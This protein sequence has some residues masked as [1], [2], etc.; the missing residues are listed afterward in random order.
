MKKRCSLFWLSSFIYT[1]LELP[2]WWHIACVHSNFFYLHK[3]L[4]YLPPPSLLFACLTGLIGHIRLRNIPRLIKKLWISIDFYCLLYK[5][6][7][8]RGFSKSTWTKLFFWPPSPLLD[9]FLKRLIYCGHFCGVRIFG[10]TPLLFF[11]LLWQWAY[12]TQSSCPV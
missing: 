4:I 9:H 2:K 8:N 1:S 5:I 6:V 7:Q 10:K 12:K 3:N 11:W